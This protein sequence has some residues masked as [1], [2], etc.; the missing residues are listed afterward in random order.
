MASMIDILGAMFI[1]S[2]LIL[3]AMTAMDNGVRQFVNHNV[4]AIVQNELVVTTEILQYDLRKMGYGIPEN[5]QSNII[6]IAQPT[7]VKYIS[8]LNSDNDTIP[9]TIEY[10]ITPFDTVTF[11]DTSFV[12]YGIERT[13]KLSD[14]ATV[15]AQISVISNNTVFRFLDQIGDSAEVIQAINMIEVTLVAMNPHVYVSEE[16]LGAGGPEERMIELRKLIRESYWRQTRVV[17][18][19]LRR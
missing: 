12:L 16:V 18:K 11:I 17:S 14:E 10:S 2:I 13:V 4:D 5:Q 9:D 19:N 1:G 7:Q 8:N 6:Q 3:I 15:S